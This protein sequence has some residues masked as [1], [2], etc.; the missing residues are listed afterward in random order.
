MTVTF[1]LN[2]LLGVKVYIW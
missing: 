2:F 1:S